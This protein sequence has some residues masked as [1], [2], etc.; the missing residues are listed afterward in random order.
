MKIWIT[1]ETAGGSLLALM[2]SGVQLGVVCLRT[3]ILKKV[4]ALN[5]KEGSFV[6]RT[7]VVVEPEKV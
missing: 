3:A 2:L 7:D 5:G 1:K 6:M 4:L